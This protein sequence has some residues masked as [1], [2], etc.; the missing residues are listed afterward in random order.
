MLSEAIKNAISPDLSKYDSGKVPCS[1]RPLNISVNVFIESLRDI[2]SQCVVDFYLRQSWVDCY[3]AD[4]INYSS[5]STTTTPVQLVLQPGDFTGFTFQEQ[6][7]WLPDSYFFQVRQAD[8]GLGPMQH[9]IRVDKYGSVLLS[10]KVN[11]FAQILSP[12]SLEVSQV[13]QTTVKFSC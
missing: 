1:P 6:K 10:Q 13:F 3:I 8:M 5:T 11:L 9:F 7:V 12:F 2:T 4:S